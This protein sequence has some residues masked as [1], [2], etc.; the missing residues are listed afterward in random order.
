LHGFY[1]DVAGFGP[2]ETSSRIAMSA[3]S[4]TLKSYGDTEGAGPVLLIIPAP[5]KR[6]YIWDLDPQA[7]VVRHCLR[8]NIR[9]YL[10]Q[11]ERHRD[12]TLGLAQ[13]A[14]EFI[15]ACLSIML[16]GHTEGGEKRNQA[17][18]FSQTS[19]R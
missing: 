2:E 16:R 1:L 18:T 17:R 9:V 14:D 11:W 15:M 7:S 19:P 12:K 3:P 4:L 5:I 6:A 10:I 13:Y 8:H